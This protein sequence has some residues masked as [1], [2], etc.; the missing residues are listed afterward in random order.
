MTDDPIEDARS[1]RD[2]ARDLLVNGR[3]DE[4]RAAFEGAERT[5]RASGEPI[6]AA[7]CRLGIGTVEVQLGHYDRAR[8]AFTEAGRS[9]QEN[10]SSLVALCVLGL[11]DVELQLENYA[12]SLAAYT[13]ANAILTEVHKPVEAAIACLGAGDVERRL[14]RLAEARGSYTNAMMGFLAVQNDLG[15]A[16]CQVRVGDLESELQCFDDAIASYFEA[17]AIFE[18]HSQFAD[19]AQCRRKV[20][21]IRY[22]LHDYDDAHAEYVDA[23]AE[24]AA[25]GMSVEAAYCTLAIA[26]VALSL[27]RI[28]EARAG[29]AKAEATFIEC[30]EPVGVAACYLGTGNVELRLKRIAEAADA[31]VAAEQIFAVHDDLD[32]SVACQM[33]IGH[34]ELERG[35]HDAALAAYTDAK[36][37]LTAQGRGDA[38]A[39]CWFSIGNVARRR[40]QWVEAAAAFTEAARSSNDAGDVLNSARARKELALITLMNES[41]DSFGDR[42]DESLGLVLSAL[43]VLDGWRYR[44]AHPLDRRRWMVQVSELYDL[45]FGL[46]GDDSRLNAELIESIRT[47]AVPLGASRAGAR[48]E[49]ELDSPEPDLILSREPRASTPSRRPPPLMASRSFTRAELGLAS[50]V[51]A[52]G[53]FPLAPP[54]AVSVAGVSA[55][56]QAS[57][58]NRV[59]EAVE[60][61]AR[62]VGGDEAW[63]WGLLVWGN[64]VRWSLHRPNLPVLAGHQPLRR[65]LLDRLA[66]AIARPLPAEL[67]A[68]EQLVPDDA[69]RRKI[70]TMVAVARVIGGPLVG[71]RALSEELQRCLPSDVQ[72]LV[73]PPAPV[74]AGRALARELGDWLVPPVLAEALHASLTPGAEPVR[75]LISVSGDLADVPIAWLAI[76]DD[77]ADGVATMLPPPDTVEFLDRLLTDLTDEPSWYERRAHSA[78]HRGPTAASTVKVALSDHEVDLD[79]SGDPRRLVEAAH[80]QMVPT[81]GLIAATSRRSVPACEP[82]VVAILDPTRDL[83]GA[84][85]RPIGATHVLGDQ[86]SGVS[87]DAVMTTLTAVPAGAQGLLVYE[88]HH[89]APHPDAPADTGGFELT[90]PDGPLLLTPRTF[91]QPPDHTD[92]DGRARPNCPRR[93]L[94]F[95]CDTHG[96]NTPGEW[97]SMTIALIWAGADEVCATIWPTLDDSAELEWPLMDQAANSDESLATM[98][99][100]AQLELL[101]RHRQQPHPSTSPYVWAGYTVTATA[102]T[103]EHGATTPQ[104]PTDSDDDDTA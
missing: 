43:S 84:R 61:A 68:L 82:V 3:N 70:A 44:L 52:T 25:S 79:D 21:D 50:A 36:R 49:S 63:W 6:E 17:Q 11:A 87:V 40:G 80:V 53:A 102:R 46:C 77:S 45:A 8:A 66:A 67:A 58:E 96:A 56:A 18:A 35:N 83:R 39:K 51:A 5:F 32:G 86:L 33:S 9:L 14:G 74:D 71:A 34:I 88:G 104:R 28:D 75:L 16:R 72:H 20:G 64:E 76:P 29:I 78:R 60:D 37:T 47:H 15:V 99:R 48:V 2:Q 100:C 55:L 57:T 27:G 85:R 97:L 98:L 22:R 23:R 38:V 10:D 24:F 93:A 19:S 54:P 26:S 69:D 4:A 62:A 101:R 73:P 91:L 103:T 94:L 81:V 41:I 42:C 31:Y 89:R 59:T 65:D 30:H 13:L 12:E 1:L 7:L 95:G 92:V 90:G